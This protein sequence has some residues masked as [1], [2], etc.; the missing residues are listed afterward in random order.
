MRLVI[1][2]A[3]KLG[4]DPVLTVGGCWL[5]VLMGGSC[6][7]SQFHLHP[8]R[9]LTPSPTF[10]IPPFMPLT[11]YA[12]YTI[13]YLV[14][15]ILFLFNLSHVLLNLC[16][17]T[18]SNF[19]TTALYSPN[20]APPVI[21]YNKNSTDRIPVKNNTNT[22]YSCYGPTAPQPSP[23]FSY[24]SPHSTTHVNQFHTA[25]ILHLRSINFL[26]TTITLI[27]QRTLQST[28]YT[29]P[30]DKGLLLHHSSHHPNAC[31]KGVIYSQ[32]LRYRRIITNEHDL[33]KHLQRLHKILLTRGYSHSTIIFTFIQATSHTQHQLLLSGSRPH[34]SP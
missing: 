15:L 2:K 3:G 25:T 23:T 24:T 17:C 29:K 32:A 34:F 4:A 8:F 12:F 7:R 10:H 14:V 26:D 28:L 1:S 20:F 22:T 27:P 19:T 31:K 16:V 18:H 30:T 11:I 9:A 5:I 6:L 33:N 13:S 21:T